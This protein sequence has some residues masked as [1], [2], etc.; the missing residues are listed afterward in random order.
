MR[1]E[2]AF[3]ARL[4]AERVLATF[5]RARG[6]VEAREFPL[7]RRVAAADARRSRPSG[8]LFLATR[9]RAPESK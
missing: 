6:A 9:L 1:F 2:S 4:A 7:V 3:T 8:T 5:L